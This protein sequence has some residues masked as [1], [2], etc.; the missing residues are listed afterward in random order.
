MQET[1]V[2]SL[3]QEDP[4]CR[5]TKRVRYNSWACALE[6][7]NLNYWVYVSQLLKPTPLTART[8]QQ[9]KPLQWEACTPQLERNPCLLQLEKNL[10]S[11]EGPAQPKINSLTNL[12]KKTDKR[13]KRLVMDWEIFKN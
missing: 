5:A 2:R 11:N 10:G 3:I 13:M 7:Q 1:W 9:E 12:K 8:L 4:A 6:P